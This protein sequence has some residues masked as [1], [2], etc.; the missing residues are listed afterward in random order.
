MD[1]TDF[2]KLLL[3]VNNG[4]VEKGVIRDM[5]LDARGHCIVDDGIHGITFVTSGVPEFKGLVN[6]CCSC[7]T[8]L[9]FNACIDLLNNNKLLD[10]T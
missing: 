7:N 2:D 3:L 8:E 5:E 6:G 10:G 4:E 9:L 1:G